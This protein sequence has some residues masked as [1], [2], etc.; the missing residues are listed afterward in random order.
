M[1]VNSFLH[2]PQYQLSDTCYTTKVLYLQKCNSANGGR[3]FV[4]YIPAFEHSS[5]GYDMCNHK[6]K[7]VE[8][9]MTLTLKVKG[10]THKANA[11]ES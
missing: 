5:V 9:N 10:P 2:V 8:Q 7:H 4:F 11:P 6:I 3:M 1:Y